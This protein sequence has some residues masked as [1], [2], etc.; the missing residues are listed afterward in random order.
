MW[1]CY[2]DIRGCR[3]TDGGNMWSFDYTGTTANS[4]YRVAEHSNG[5]LFAG[6]SSIHDMYQSTRLQNNPLDNADSE[7]KIIYST[8]DGASWQLIHNFGHPVFWIALDPNNINRA[9]ASVVSS[10]AGGIYICNDLNNLG[11]SS[12]TL[13]SAPPRTEGHPASLVVLNDGKLVATYSGHRNPG[14][15]ASSGVFIYDPV[16]MSWTDVSDP[17][18]LYWTKDVVIDPNDASQNTWYVSVF[19]GWGGAPNGLGGLYKTTNRGTSWNKLTGSTLD[20]VTS[21]TFNPNNANEVYVTT[22]VQGLWI[23]SNINSGTPTFSQVTSYP[24]R[25]P[26]RVFFNP[27]NN[28]EVWVTSFGNGMKVGLIN[29]PAGMADFSESIFKVYPNPANSFVNVQY[30]G[31]ENIRVN[32]IDLNGKVVGSHLLKPGIN[33]LDVS[34]LANGVYSLGVNGKYEKILIC[35]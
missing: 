26:E 4:S 13:L 32:M 27:Y 21:C 6:T 20:R 19:S 10:V 5:N 30:N 33:T 35:H 15:T 31:D 23:S 17:G 8:D 24:F 28:N 2:S 29:N 11:S 9:Y 14:F 34:M 12:W 22:E 3:S 16:G 18:M 1:A 7:G 25:Q